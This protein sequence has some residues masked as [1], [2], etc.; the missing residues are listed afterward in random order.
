ML[1]SDATNPARVGDAAGLGICSLRGC[2]NSPDTAPNSPVNQALRLRCL[3]PR[4]HNLGP[5]TL[6]YFL[7]EVARGREVMTAAEDYAA[8][9]PD[10]DLIREYAVRPGPF[11]IEGGRR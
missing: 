10:A 8:L 1:V 2:E 3:A 4:I 11:A 5:I 9:V 7:E 6:A